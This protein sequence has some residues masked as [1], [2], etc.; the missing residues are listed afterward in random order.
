VENL[1]LTL[2]WILTRLLQ[3]HQS[4]DIGTFPALTLFSQYS[5]NF[6]LLISSDFNPVLHVPVRT[7]WLGYFCIPLP[8]TLGYDPLYIKNST[9]IVEISCKSTK[10]LILLDLLL[11]THLCH[12]PQ[13]PQPKPKPKPWSYLDLSLNTLPGDTPTQKHIPRH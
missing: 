1:E 11:K 2:G 12:S 5:N 7:V 4:T 3:S 9:H 6:T 10:V 8:P 13:D